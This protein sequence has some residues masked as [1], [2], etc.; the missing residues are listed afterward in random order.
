MDELNTL[1][2]TLEDLFDKHR[3]MPYIRDEL[4]KVDSIME[5]IQFY[6]LDEKFVFDLMAQMIVHRRCTADTLVGCLYHHYDDA[7]KTSDEIL[8]CVEADLVDFSR[9]SLSFTTVI[10]PDAEMQSAIDRFQFPLPLVIEPRKLTANDNSGYHFIK[11]TSVI[12][13]DNHH[14]DDVNLDHLNRVN[15][16]PLAIN[17]KVAMYMSNKWKGIDQPK[18]GETRDEYKKRVKAFQKYDRT[19]RAV[20]AMLGEHTNK[21][22]LTHAYDTRGRSYCVGYHLNYQGNS[23]NKAVVEFADKE[24]IPC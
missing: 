16:I 11:G 4:R 10:T 3:L 18:D 24:I 9:V 15:S 22:Y 12:L 17:S 21:L 20:M 14:T 23:W 6:E 19:S 5:T 8:K 13:R 2:Y 7:Q 1:Q